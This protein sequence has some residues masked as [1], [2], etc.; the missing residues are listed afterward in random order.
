MALFH[1]IL[2]VLVSLP[3]RSYAID[4][5]LE[6]GF[7]NPPHESCPL[8]WWHWMDGNVSKVGITADLEAMKRI[9]LRGCLAFNVSYGLPHGAARFM[10]AHWLDLLDHTVREAGR[11]GLAFGVHNC[12]GW[13]QAGGPW[14]TP[15]RS[16]KVLTWTTIEVEGPRSFDALLKQPNSRH[17]FYRDIAVIAFPTPTGRRLNTMESGVTVRGEGSGDVRRLIDGNP[18]STADFPACAEAEHT[19]LFEFEESVT[20]RS[21]S[22]GNYRRYE[23]TREVPAVLEVSADG[24]NLHE[25]TTFDL[26]WSFRQYRD[27]SYTAAFEPAE[28]TVFRLRF[29][30]EWP[31]QIGEIALSDVARVHY[32]QAKAGWVIR[33]QHGGETQALRASPGPPRTMD[34]QAIHTIP[35]NRIQVLTDQL[36][37]DGRLDWQAPAGRWTLLRLGYTITGKTNHPASEEGCGLECDKLDRT[38]IRV[39]LQQYL[40]QLLDRYGS[41]PDNAFNIFEVDS[42]ECGVQNWTQGLDERFRQTTGY[43]LLDWIPLLTEGWIIDSYDA[44]M[45]EPKSEH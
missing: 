17:D 10:Q 12:D 41:D 7:R 26:N 38:A 37:E 15:E 16:M 39:H 29:R 34:V 32:W 3:S 8:T 45:Q 18:A 40:K 2:L 20:A 30:N 43:A 23:M 36:Q 4:P 35:R 42:W 27:A 44:S 9:G 31:V 19:I 24:R 13:S 22:I 5:S 11:L 25:V 28:G 21:L 33:P 6:A 14:I 1:V